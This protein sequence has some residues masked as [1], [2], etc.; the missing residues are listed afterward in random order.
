[1]TVFG[2]AIA[3][4]RAIAFVPSSTTGIGGRASLTAPS[5]ARNSVRHNAH[6]L[7]GEVFLQSASDAIAGALRG[8]FTLSDRHAAEA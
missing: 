8:S 4:A 6:R 1:M 7:H 2:W 5:A 3:D